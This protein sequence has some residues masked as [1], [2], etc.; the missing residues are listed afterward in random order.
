MG[1]TLNIVDY[2]ILESINSFLTQ[3]IVF[4]S[5]SLDTEANTLILNV[6]I[7]YIFFTESF[8]KPLL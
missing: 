5:I 3:T 4:G 1:G 8:E 2:N 6:T 7:D